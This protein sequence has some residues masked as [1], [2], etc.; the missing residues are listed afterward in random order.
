MCGRIARVRAPFASQVLGPQATACD[1]V[2]RGVIAGR[3]VTFTLIS[4][5]AFAPDDGGR[6]LSDTA[7]RRLATVS[8]QAIT[9][10]CLPPGWPH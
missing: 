3:A 1:L 8:E 9:Y 5:G 6:V 2:A 7:L 10:T 4:D